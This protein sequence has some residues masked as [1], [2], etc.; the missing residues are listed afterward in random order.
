MPNPF[1]HKQSTLFQTIQFRM[2]TQFNRQKHFYF[3]RFSLVK[4]LFQT[5]PFSIS[6]RLNIKS[7]LFQAMQF[8]SIWPIDVTLLGATTPR[9]SRPGSDG[10][11]GWRDTPHSPMFR[12]YW[13]LTIRLVSI[14][15]RT[16][17]GFGGVLPLCCEVVSVYYGSSRLGN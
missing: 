14:S 8:S 17:V 10:N 7:V 11:E 12:H 3:K 2:S 6:T 16:L 15:H 13:N 9:Q 1:L 4:Q 5:N